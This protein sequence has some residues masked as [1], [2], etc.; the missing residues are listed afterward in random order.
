M[1]KDVH[2]GKGVDCESYHRDELKNS[3]I[4]ENGNLFEI[5]EELVAKNMRNVPLACSARVC[6]YN[7]DEKCYANGISV[8]D[9]ENE[10]VCATYIMR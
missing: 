10:A 4:I 9:D 6:I 1:A 2:V 3:L 8:I 7:K 5:S